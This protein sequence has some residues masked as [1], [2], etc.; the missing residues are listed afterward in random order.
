MKSAIKTIGIFLIACGVKLVEHF[1]MGLGLVLIGG[2]AYFLA[3]LDDY[4][5]PCMLREE[6]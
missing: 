2:T 4:R 5:C 3:D 6:D 1:W